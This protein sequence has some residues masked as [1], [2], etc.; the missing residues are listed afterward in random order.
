[1]T[2]ELLDL[3]KLVRAEIGEDCEGLPVGGELLSA[4]SSHHASCWQ[5]NV[6]I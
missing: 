6:H 2:E 1:M 4:L 5:P 3:Q